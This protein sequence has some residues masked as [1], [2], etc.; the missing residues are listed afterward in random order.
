MSH[1]KVRGFN[2]EQFRE[3]VPEETQ[4]LVDEFLKQS[5]KS[6]QTLIQYRSALYIFCK[7]VHDEKRNK[8][9]TE[10]K[11]RDALAY[12]NWLIDSGLGNQGIRFKRSAVSSLYNYIE[13]FWIEEY[14]NIRNIFTKAIPPVSNTKKTVKQ[15]LTVRE[16]RRIKNYLKKKE[17][18]QEYAYFCFAYSSGCRR[19]EERQLL[20]EVATYKKHVTARGKEQKYYLTHNIRAKGA[21]KAGKVR[22]F[23]F[24]QETMDAFQKWLEVRGEDDCPYMF[25]TKDKKGARQVHE[26]RFNEWCQDMNKIVNRNVHPHLIRASRATN[27]VVEE[28]KDLKAVQQLLGHESSST[29]EIYIITENDNVIDELF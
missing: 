17:L 24:D 18:W 25:V 16:V 23:Q 8:P 12:Q 7:W 14:P 13:A 26:G 11:P 19:E 10:L 20:K 2:E 29:T 27:S 21:G 28:G 6:D 22:K 9:I 3:L 1:Y 4:E 5:Q 15:P